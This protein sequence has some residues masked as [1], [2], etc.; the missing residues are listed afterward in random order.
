MDEADKG[1]N[2]GRGSQEG[3]GEAVKVNDRRRF[4]PSGNPRDP[5]PSEPPRAG[6]S[7]PGAAQPSGGSA[8]A[9]QNGPEAVRARAEADNEALRKE[10]EVARKR[11]DELARAFQALNNDREEFKQ[12]LSRERERMLDVEKG[13]IAQILLEVMDELDLSLQAAGNDD[14]PLARGVRLIR[15]GILSK[16]Q[17]LGI[18]RVDPLGEPFDPNSSEAADVEITTDPAKDQKVV[19]VTRAGYRLK[20]R[21]IRPARAK[22]AKYVKPADA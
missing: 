2:R 11:V 1:Y 10:L 18:E 6:E 22:V 5:D 21:V 8:E 15:D 12:R 19:G 16:L 14:S 7:S 4:D 17:T 3:E 9:S 13:N 20:D